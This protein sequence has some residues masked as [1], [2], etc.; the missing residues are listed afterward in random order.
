M[1]DT[2]PSSAPDA[3]ATQTS[4]PDSA[5]GATGAPTGDM[6]ASLHDVQMETA[7]ALLR[8][9]PGNEGKAEFNLKTEKDPVTG[10]FVGKGDKAGDDK[11][12][13]GAS[14]EDDPAKA[15]S[16]K[17]PE[18]DKQPTTEAPAHLAP[19]LKAVWSK[20][21]PDAQ[22]AISARTLEDRKAISRL[23]NTVKAYEPFAE[24]SNTYREYF[25]RHQ[26]HPGAVFNNLMAW[27]HALESDPVGQFPKLIETYGAKPAE[28]QAIISAL[29]RQHGLSVSPTQP[30]GSDDLS[31]PLDPATVAMQARFDALERQNQALLARLNNTEGSVR[32]MSQI[33]QERAEY[34]RLQA[35]QTQESQMSA[36][37]DGFKA[38]VD[39]TEFEFLRPYLAAEIMKV[40]SSVP[41]KDVIPTAYAKARKALEG[42][43]APK[44]SAAD[45]TKQQQAATAAAGTAK[46]IASANVRGSPPISTPVT[47]VKDAQN[48]VLRKFGLVN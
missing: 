32:Q 20:L 9:L 30:N 18:P 11:P 17:S 41:E 21:P 29:A 2:T 8:E 39:A 28:V 22:D 4:A 42:V 1:L 33:E 23:G 26:T 24:V 40:D 34:A 15:E 14:G 31:L 48:D 16:K 13:T 7:K 47:S 37:I 46:R 12:A 5:T 45:K 25:E 36:S 19:D 38:T 44:L 35:V 27:N 6:G 43:I 3:L 10:K